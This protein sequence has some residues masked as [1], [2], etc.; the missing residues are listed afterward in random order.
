MWPSWWKGGIGKQTQTCLEIA[1]EIRHKVLSITNSTVGTDPSTFTPCSW[2]V[3]FIN[4]VLL[5]TL[6]TKCCYVS[7]QTLLHLW[8]N[9]ITFCAFITFVTFIT[10]GP[11]ITFILLSELSP[12]MY[13]R[14]FLSFLFHIA[15]KNWRTE[16]H[17]KTGTKSRSAVWG[18]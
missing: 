6:V 15:K 17:K 14:I 3:R 12:F 18:A 9:L 11:A 8:P 16:E 1:F 4:I 2:P 10:F 13:Q 7:A 5:I